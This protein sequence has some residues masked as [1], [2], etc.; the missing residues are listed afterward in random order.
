MGRDFFPPVPPAE[1]TRPTKGDVVIAVLAVT[2][3]V[4]AYLTPG[5]EGPSA[6]VTVPGV[7]LVCVAAVP[8]LF[9]RHHPMPVLGAVLA[10]QLAVNTGL[11]VDPGEAMSNSYGAAVSVALYTVARYSER[12][13]VALAVVAAAPVQILRYV[14]NDEAT[15]GMGVT[16]VLVTP[17]LL[18][19][20][21]LAVRQWKRQLDINR[22]LLADRAVTEERR[23]I[24][25]EL[26]DIV[27]HHITTMYLMSGGARSTL[28]R[29]P[30][31]ARE[32]LVTLEESGRT[33]LHEMRQLLGVLRSTE[34]PEETPS[35]PQPGVNDIERLVADSVAAGLPTELHVTG[36]ARPLP[37]TVGL[38]LYRIVQEA[39]TNA[40][41]HAGP[42]RATVRIGYLPDRVTVE[43]ADDGA[44]GGDPGT[45]RTGGGYGLLGM[46]ER[47]ALHDGS[48]H[49]GN[50][51][52]GGFA[53]TAEVPLPAGTYEE[54]TQH[55]MNAIDEKDGTPR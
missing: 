32:A 41:K 33:A 13:A 20:I 29:D 55:E 19:A 9:R 17:C 37:M 43:V 45:S 1:S 2:L 27:A 10:V 25:R 21:G 30:E 23:R 26:H 16:D 5:E 36:R 40:R 44:G 15:L 8:L 11:V 18:V 51:A 47:I 53:V 48:L 7:L 28:D 35:E 12:R 38:T 50:R 24:A 6:R 14:N 4:L 39:L 49:V 34:T 42:A 54:H 46:R 31:T 3:D 52:G 22:K